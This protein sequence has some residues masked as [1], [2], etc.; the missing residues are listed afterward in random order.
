MRSAGTSRR[1]RA[2][3]YGIVTAAIVLVLALTEWWIEKYV[4]D[5]SR[6]AGTTIEA[7][8]VAVAAFVVPAD[9]STR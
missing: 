9:P 1:L 6:L 8:I 4:S 3:A 2:Y 7:S 5:R